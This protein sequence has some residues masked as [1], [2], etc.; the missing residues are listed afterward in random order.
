ML[1]DNTPIGQTLSVHDTAI[2]LGKL[3]R[4]YRGKDVLVMDLRNIN[5]WTDFF[6]IATVTSNIH[7]Q[8]LERHIREFSREKGID[9]LRVSPRPQGGRYASE[10]QW[11]IIDLGPL[12]IH[13]MTP[14]TRSF[15]ELERLW[16]A[17]AVIFQESPVAAVQD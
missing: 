10:D 13:L 1:K 8:G 3:L 17:A 16:N 7:L 12:V 11:L 2:E 9:I 15:Y 4:D 14:K 6:V 5:G